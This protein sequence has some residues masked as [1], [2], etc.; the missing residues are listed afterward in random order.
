MRVLLP[1]FQF[2]CLFFFLSDA[3]AR[4]S[5]TM[6]NK[7]DESGHPY[8]VPDLKGNTCSFCPFSIML[9]VYLSYMAFTMFRYVSSIPN[10]LRALSYMGAKFYDVFFHIS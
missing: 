7:S 9:A 4:T 1:L 2:G 3:V 6:L 8:V 5:S 10:L